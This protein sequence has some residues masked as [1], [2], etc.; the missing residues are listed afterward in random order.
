MYVCHCEVVSDQR[1]RDVI[2]S[3][4]DDIGA[5]TAACGAGGGCGGCHPAIEDLLAEAALAIRDPRLLRAH[6]SMRR[7]LAGVAAAALLR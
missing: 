1:I 3:G 5:V 4:A 7:P 2:A 6:Q